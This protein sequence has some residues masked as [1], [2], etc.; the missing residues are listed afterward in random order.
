LRADTHRQIGG[1]GRAEGDSR[2]LGHGPRRV[3]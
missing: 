3:G 2:T 1:S